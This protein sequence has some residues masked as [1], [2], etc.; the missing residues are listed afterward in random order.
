MKI[1]MDRKEIEAVLLDWVV[2]KFGAEF[3]TVE[4]ANYH[5]PSSVEFS[6]SK[7]NDIAPPP[8]A[9]STDDDPL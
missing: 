1:E 7:E 6:N 8:K 3:N 4:W 5:R 2:A 9:A